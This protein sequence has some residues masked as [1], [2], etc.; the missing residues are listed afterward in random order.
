MVSTRASPAACVVA[1]LARHVVTW[2]SASS[3][4]D[5]DDLRLDCWM[6]EVRSR[7]H[8][9]NRVAGSVACYNA[10]RDSERTHRTG[11]QP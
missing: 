5:F 7:W 3:L 1:H 11:N 8:R 2:R 4:V 10:Q 9:P 6:K